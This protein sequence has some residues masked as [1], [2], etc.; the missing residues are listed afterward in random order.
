M[1]SIAS[2]NSARIAVLVRRLSSEK[3]G[4]EGATSVEFA[5]IAPIFL[6]FVYGLL[7]FGRV[8]F[9]MAV[10]YFAAEEASRFSVVNY[11][12][13]TTEIRQVAENKF[14]L[15]DTAKISKFEV[16]SVLNTVDQTK[17]VT[18][19]IVY[20]FTPLVPLVWTTINLRGHS[21]GFIVDK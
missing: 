4:S 11:T 15:I 12:A 20:A 18:I 19:D 8:L 9:T 3:H 2:A 13:T 5:L 21:R 14:L 7:E 17:L 6:V 16:T 1:T 10:L